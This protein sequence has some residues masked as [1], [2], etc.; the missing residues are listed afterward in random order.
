MNMAAGSPETFSDEF[1]VAAG[2]YPQS[3]FLAVSSSATRDYHQRGYEITY[4]HAVDAISMLRGAYV[5]AGI[6]HGH[7]VALML[8]NR[9]EHIL[10]F[11]ALNGLGAGLVPVNTDY[12]HHELFYL[13]DHSEADL[14]V[15]LPKHRDRMSRVAAERTKPLPVV[16][17]DAETAL[18]LGSMP[19]V[20]PPPLAGPPLRT[21]EAA[22]MYTSGTTGRPKGC[23][24]DNAYV[25]NAAHWYASMGGRMALRPGI[26]RVINPLPLFHVNAGII[27]LGAMVV[28]GGCQIVPDRFHPS[29]WWRDLVETRATIMHY[30]GIMPPIL[31]KQA[32]VPEETAHNLSFGLGAGID[33]AI[34]PPF[35]QRFR[36]PMV[37]LWGMTET[38]RLIG[39]AL[40]PRTIT[41]RAFGRPSGDLEAKVV[42]DNDMELPRGTPGELL[43]RCKGPDPRRYFF[44]GYLKDPEATET[45]WRGG[46]FHTGD[47]V[48]QA[49]D[50]L[51][52]FVERRKNIIRR[53]GE[54]ISAAEVE[55]GILEHPAI[56]KVTAISVPDEL[57]DEEV[58]ACIVL[59]AGVAPDRATAESI[60]AFGRERL[61]YFKV[62]GWIVFVDDLPTTSTQKVQKAL[63]FEKGSDPR[64]HA[65]AHDLRALKKRASD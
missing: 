57:R 44:R 35:E 16:A 65:R 64:H 55:N 30:L 14:A 31:M 49:P 54:N 11:L 12:M 7:R 6:G 13:L 4:R 45:A 22:L 46:W 38:G 52:T 40:E 3:A 36:V 41:T 1:S 23:I 27:S 48:T 17:V 9:P 62:P 25:L 29:T 20:A 28:T 19:E 33:P 56:A 58:M 18:E 5:R 42:D 43:V 60:A 59:S 51:L 2:R 10:H 37:E 24:L 21:T 26:E 47:V 15:V 63:I 8:D 61:A 39:D 34:H 50:G 53:S 32:P